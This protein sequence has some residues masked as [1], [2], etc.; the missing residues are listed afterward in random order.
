M[1]WVTL[2]LVTC[3]ADILLS[4]KENRPAA[5]SLQMGEDEHHCMNRRVSLQ[6]TQV[7]WHPVPASTKGTNAARSEMQDETAVRI[8]EGLRSNPRVG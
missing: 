6:F 3:L 5:W 7:C 2:T 8:R 4:D 1:I